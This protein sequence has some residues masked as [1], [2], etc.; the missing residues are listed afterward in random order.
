MSFSAGLSNTKYFSYGMLGFASVLTAFNSY[1]LNATRS[2][3]SK[4]PIN[5]ITGLVESIHAS[6]SVVCLQFLISIYLTYSIYTKQSKIQLPFEGMYKTYATVLTFPMIFLGLYIYLE[7][8]LSEVKDK[9]I[10]EQTIFQNVAI[11]IFSLSVVYLLFSIFIIYVVS[12]DKGLES[13]CK[14][15]TLDVNPYVMEFSQEKRVE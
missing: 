13:L 8:H 1:I 10:G 2:I 12:K 14:F 6:F 9:P 15:Y 3:D 7:V 4:T 5:E 11:S